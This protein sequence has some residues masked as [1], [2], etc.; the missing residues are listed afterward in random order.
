MAL[1]GKKEPEAKAPGS[2]PTQPDNRNVPKESKKA[3]PKPTPKPKASD[4]RK[5]TTYLGKNLKINGTVSGDGNLI[6]LG[7]FDGEFDIKGQLK[8]AQGAVIKGNIN[9]TGV[10]I[11]GNVDGT[12]VARERILLDTT[13][14]M[15]GRLVTPKIS[16]Q[17]GAIF[18]GELQMSGKSGAPQSQAPK[19]AASEAKPTPK[20]PSVSEIK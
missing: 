16:I 7:T 14:S 18:D 12:I 19:P 6:I 3:P 4:G 8:V 15:K 10:S 1:F 13:A 2:Q 9:A 11:N 5:D 20:Q 17:D